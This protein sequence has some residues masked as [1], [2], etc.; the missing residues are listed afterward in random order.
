MGYLILL[1]HQPIEPGSYAQ[2]DTMMQIMVGVAGVLLI[3]L[4]VI[5]RMK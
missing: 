5:W 2:M 4:G 1:Q 3:A